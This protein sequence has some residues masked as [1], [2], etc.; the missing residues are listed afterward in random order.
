MHLFKYDKYIIEVLDNIF[1][2]INILKFDLSDFNKNYKNI[3]LLYKVNYNDEINSITKILITSYLILVLFINNDSDKIKTFL[4]KEKILNDYLVIV[5]NLFDT[6]QNIQKILEIGNQ[7][8][9]ILLYKNNPKYIDSINTLNKIG[10]QNVV[11]N[12]KSSNKKLNIH[13]LIKVILINDSNLKF[14]RKY[15][16]K[17]I[18]LLSLD[19]SKFDT[20][21]IIEDKFNYIDYNSIESVLN[22]NEKQFVEQTFKDA[23]IQKYITIITAKPIFCHSPKIQLK[24]S[25]S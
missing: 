3:N 13:N 4:I 17:K 7:N 22:I 8:D 24:K 2:K 18:F 14:Y 19:K 16:R 23:F 9:V 25:N 11:T 10:Y 15:F 20:I 12:F 6:F 1:K 21:N 5:I